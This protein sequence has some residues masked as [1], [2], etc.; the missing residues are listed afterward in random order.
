MTTFPTIQSTLSSKALATF[1][2]EKYSLT[3]NTTCKLLKTG[4]NHTYQIDCEENSYIL[5]VYCFQWRTKEEISEELRLLN[6]LK[7]QNINVSFPIVDHSGNMIQTINAAEGQRYAVLFSY[8]KG[9][10]IQNYSIEAHFEI[11]KLMAQIHSHTNNL[12]LNR[13]NYTSENLINQSL[14]YIEPFISNE[15]DEMKFLQRLKPVLE[16]ELNN[17]MK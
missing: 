17:R 2:C 14:N 11:G 16:K 6:L 4:I 13:S 15:S 3:S 7:Q 5:R 9:N 12:K 8:A 1:V 10:K